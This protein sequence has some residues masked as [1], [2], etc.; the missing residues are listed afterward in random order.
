[1]IDTKKLMHLTR[2]QQLDIIKCKVAVARRALE[3]SKGENP[4]VIELMQQYVV[5]AETVLEK[6]MWSLK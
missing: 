6:A 2:D 3:L 4:E 5:E 1:M